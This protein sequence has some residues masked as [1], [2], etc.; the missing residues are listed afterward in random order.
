M[1]DQDN[2]PE[3]SAIPLE[4]GE[5]DATIQNTEF[6]R[7]QPMQISEEMRRSYLNYAMSVIVSRALPDVRDGLKPVHRRILF[8]MKDMGLTSTTSFKKCARIVGEVLGKYHP[9]GDT[10]VYDALVRLAQDFSMRYRLIRG[11]GNFG[12]VDGDAP[13][14]MRYTEAK[15]EKITDELLVDI[16][17]QTVDFVDNFDGSQQEP[18]V[19]PAN[20]PNLLLMGSEGIAVGMATKIPPH[21]LNELID[22]IALLIQKGDSQVEEIS[23]GVV[24]DSLNRALARASKELAKQLPKPLEGSELVEAHP[25]SLAGTFHSSAAID[26]LLE[27]IKG[28]DFP[29]G[30][31]IYDW[32]EIKRVYHTGKG[33]ILTRGKVSIEETGKE[34]NQI[35]ITELPYQVNKAKLIEKIADLA[36]DKKLIGIADIRDESDRRGMRIAIDL[37]RDAKPKS[38]LNNLYK[39]TP[40]Q[41]NFPANIVALNADGTPQLMNLKTILS[42]YVRH[43]QLVVVRRSQYELLSAGQRAHILEGLLIALDHLDEVITT[44]RNSPDA[45][46]AKARLMEKFTLSEMQ[47]T[48]IL[49]M[50]LRKLAALE[51]KK[52]DDEYATIKAKID[53]LIGLLKNPSKILEVIASELTALKEIYGDARLTRV[54]KGGVGEMNEEDFV[55]KEETVVTFTQSGYV[56]R[57]PPST[58]KSQRRGGKGVS[59]MTTK[60][61]DVITHIFMANTHDNLLVFTNKGKVFRLKVYELPEASRQAKGQNI[62]NLINIDQDEVIQSVIPISGDLAQHQEKFIALA[63]R[64]G[65]VKKTSITEFQNIRTT[66]I[67]AI[68]L[69]PDDS[70]VWGDITSGNRDMLMV[71]NQGKSIRF[72]EQEIRS[73]ARDTKGVRGIELKHNDFVV[74]VEAI[75][76]T[77][78][79]PE[80]RRRR[81]FHDLLIITQKGMGKRTPFDDYPKQKRGGQG[82]KT[83]NITP[84]TGN[85]A[86]AMSVTQAVEQVLITTSAGQVIKL[87]LR[88]IPQLKRPTQGVILM[89]LAKA[90]D[91]VVS[92]ATVEADEDDSSE[93]SA[94]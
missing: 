66:G 37:K 58:Y 30:G 50:Q 64:K 14:A 3:T 71:T 33:R 73:T 74:A 12:S 79:A 9:H 26:E 76:T 43:R 47:S 31:I 87:P 80:D 88:N 65:I 77:I 25:R 42:E 69:N 59:G 35:I 46:T 6:G 40:L 82:V 20:L 51:R 53:Y 49:D 13:A 68:I 55:A 21:N 36:R 45:D 1:S 62:I 29:T 18:T 27:H 81:F 84:K 16:D 78:Q 83:A 57:L 63:T 60:E 91:K 75:N 41:S 22:A 89:R 5:F 24:D 86:A 28:P 17:K 90:A 39:H 4:N 85:I 72:S 61:D 7:V 11:Q 2:L 38:L 32:N 48:A 94:E 92:A 8:A 67:I 10:A 56:K 23:E 93:P 44:I 15:L 19:L 54:V 52:I 70:L 34:R